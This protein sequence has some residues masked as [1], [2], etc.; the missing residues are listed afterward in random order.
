MSLRLLAV[1]FIVLPLLVYGAVGV[2]R[3]QQIRGE[4]EVRLDRALRIA[5]EHA[6]KVFE[7]NTSRLERTMELLE[8]ADPAALRPRE[9]ELHERMRRLTGSRS[10]VRSVWVFDAEGRPVVTDR[11]YPVTSE[12]LAADRDYFRIHADGSGQPYVSGPLVGRNSGMQFFSLSRGRRLAD[13]RFGGVVSVF[14]PTDVFE[15]FHDDL[16]ADEP[17]LAITMLREDGTILTRWPPIPNAPVALS[18]NSPVMTK[19]RAGALQGTAHGISSVDGRLR[20]LTFAKV[21]EQP[22]FLGTGMDTMEIRKRWLAEMGWLATFGVPPLVA[23]FFVAALALRRTRDALEAAQQLSAEAEARRRVEEALLQAQKLEALGRLTGGVAH[24]FNNALMVISNN[25]FLL[26][27]RHPG[28]ATELEPIGRAVGSATK[29]TRQLLAFSRRQAQVPEQA[30]LQDTL[31]RLREML[32]PVLGGGVAL[33]IDVADDTRPISVDSA[34][35]ELAMINLA[36][37]ARD[38]M[39]EG[40]RFTLRARN[41]GT[42]VPPLFDADLVLVEAIDT[43]VGIDEAIIGTV[44]EPFFTTKPVGQGTGLGL[45]QIYGMCQRAGGTASIASSPGAG[46][47]VRLYF[48]ACDAQQPAPAE[49]PGESPMPL[50]TSVLLVEDND[51]VAAA[52]QPVLEACGCTVTRLDRARAA[53]QWLAEQAVLP[54]LLLSDV[55]MPGDL[56]GLGLAQYVRATYPGIRILLMTGYAEQIDAIAAQRFEILPK[57]CDAQALSAAIARGAQGAPP[58]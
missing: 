6:Q 22:V 9:R 56:D 35:F 30:R 13:G 34:E 21:G 43:G 33:S 17:G 47:T 16:A 53:Q 36:V 7:T 14:V 31:P 40:G 49:R 5:L 29:L 23:L 26:R 45:S 50:G 11:V 15:K 28:I 32:A 58:A 10:P 24:D 42:D 2:A 27:R 20:L 54:D 38:A 55:V 51:D 8:D 57:P 19:I 37:N 3:F 18:P 39:P 52:L 46:T 12:T 1:L 41:A 25:L 4:T 48:A 44:F